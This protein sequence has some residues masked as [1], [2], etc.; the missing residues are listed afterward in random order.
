MNAERVCDAD[1]RPHVR[2]LFAV[3]VLLIRSHRDPCFFR[4]LKLCLAGCFA[5]FF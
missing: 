5:D 2:T 3:L 1:C 4:D